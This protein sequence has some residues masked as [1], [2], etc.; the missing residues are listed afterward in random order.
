MTLKISDLSSSGQSSNSWKINQ[1][2]HTYLL[3]Q[4]FVCPRSCGWAGMGA[5]AHPGLCELSVLAW[6]RRHQRFPA[7]PLHSQSQRNKYFHFLK[8]AFSLSL[9]WVLIFFFSFSH[10]SL[11]IALEQ[12]SP[13]PRIATHNVQWWTL[14]HLTWTPS[15]KVCGKAL[16]KCLGIFPWFL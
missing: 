15:F 11:E 13:R 10:L 8:H 5:S 3:S 7:I 4:E 1:A 14:G 16:W 12:I 6:D 2:S 9:P